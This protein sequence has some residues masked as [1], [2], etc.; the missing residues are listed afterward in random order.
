MNT[1]LVTLPRLYLC[2]P[3]TGLPEFNYPAFTRAA[4]QLRG[5]GYTVFTPTEN[6]LPQHAP[7]GMHMRRDIPQ[8]VRCGG[9]AVLP[10]HEASRG[11]QLEL[12]I[13]T[14]LGIPVAPVDTWMATIK[15][16]PADAEPTYSPMTGEP[17]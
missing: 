4:N 14:E 5:L 10:G 11:A 8:L 13:A 9:V 12:Y 7:W 1:T 3:M 16:T 6:G 15:Y 2:G 17:L